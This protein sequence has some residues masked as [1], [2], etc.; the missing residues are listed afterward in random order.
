M[1]YS[2]EEK[3]K[4]HN[5]LDKIMLY[6]DG[7]RQDLREE[8]TIDFGPVK[9]YADW[10]KE[11]A[12]HITV[13]K[14]GISCRSGGLGFDFIDPFKSA[15]R[16]TAYSQLDFAVALIQNWFTVKSTVNNAIKEQQRMFDCINNFEV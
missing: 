10:S 8:V 12:Y 3:E 1:T 13:S 2:K 16:V 15:Y 7:I 5:N 9:T 11:K 4:I 6:L 14:D